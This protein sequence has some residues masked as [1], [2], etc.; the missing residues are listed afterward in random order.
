MDGQ[1]EPEK[2]YP[3]N[4]GKKT[5]AIGKKWLKFIEID[6]VIVIATPKNIQMISFSEAQPKKNQCVKLL[7]EVT[8]VRQNKFSQILK[9]AKKLQSHFFLKAEPSNGE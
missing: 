7:F 1:I 2:H 9:L 5:Q 3:A 6:Y 8:M 4:R